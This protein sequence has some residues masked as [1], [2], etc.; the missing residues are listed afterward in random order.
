MQRDSARVISEWWDMKLMYHRK[1]LLAQCCGIAPPPH[2]LL[3]G[4]VSIPY[5]LVA[6]DICQIPFLFLLIRPACVHRP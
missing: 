4:K 2:R 6:K 1:S 5:T 3:S